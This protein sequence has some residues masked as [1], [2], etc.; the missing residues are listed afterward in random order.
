MYLCRTWDMWEKNP[1]EASSVA[2]FLH[3][4]RYKLFEGHPTATADGLHDLTNLC[5]QQDR[6]NFEIP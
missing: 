6:L 3:Y 4:C 1:K 5:Q 2:D